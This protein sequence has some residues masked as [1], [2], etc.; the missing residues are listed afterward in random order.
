MNVPKHR[1]IAVFVFLF[2]SGFLSGGTERQS[3][4][5]VLNS[6]YSLF[7]GRV[8]G[9]QGHLLTMT[10]PGVPLLVQPDDLN[11]ER[12]LSL[13]L[14]RIPQPKILYEGSDLGTIQQAYADLLERIHFKSAN[15][16]SVESKTTD[17]RSLLFTGDSK[18]HSYDLYLHYKDVYDSSSRS[19]KDPNKPTIAERQQIANALQDWRDLGRKD[20]I[21]EALSVLNAE[22]RMNP[23]NR[24]DTLRAQFKKYTKT[25]AKG[26]FQ[27]IQTFPAISSWNL[28][29]IWSLLSISSI[30][31]SSAI[32]KSSASFDASLGLWSFGSKANA[33][34][35]RKSVQGTKLTGEVARVALIRPWLATDLLSQNDWYLNDKGNESREPAIPLLCTDVLLAR[36]VHL[37]SLAKSEVKALRQAIT[38]K[39]RTG[40]GPFAVSGY[41][42]NNPEE[43][44]LSPIIGSDSITVP[45]TQVV[46][47]YCVSI[48]G[49]AN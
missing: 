15:S 17:A 10:Y 47:W 34:E 25:T 4:A 26:D 12:L 44:Y 45:F 20:Q 27:L 22:E 38:D 24:L 43:K 18:S 31:S 48:T 5:N 11:T 14:D 13:T 40:W 16:T 19:V 1:R 23:E 39:R 37:V 6:I 32:N 7:S 33:I 46:G 42:F 3:D 36:N 49:K 29:Q 8:P 9:K 35:H 28:P 30:G 41:A 2:A 21:E